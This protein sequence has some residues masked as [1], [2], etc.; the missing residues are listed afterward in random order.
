[1]KNTCGKLCELVEKDGKTTEEGLCVGKFSEIKR[2]YA[3]FTNKMKEKVEN[4]YNA[5]K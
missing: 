3:S 4:E 1:M 5:R 2:K